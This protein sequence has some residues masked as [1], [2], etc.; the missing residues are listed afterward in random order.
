MVVFQ[1]MNSQKSCL[2]VAILL[3]VLM[4]SGCSARRF[5]INKLGDALSQGGSTFAQDD[6]PELVRDAV[7]FSL[8]L[9]ESLLAES[10][11]HQGLLLA[12]NRG[13]AQYAY[14]FVQEDAD[15]IEA[16][17]LKTATA[18][19]ERARKL[20][21][22]AYLYGLRGIEA[23]HKGFVSQLHQDPKKALAIL[24]PADL[25]LLYWSSISWAATISLSKDRPESIADLPLVE[26]MIDR[27]L[28]LDDA[29]DH[30]ALHSFL[31]SF[32]SARKSQKGDLDQRIKLHFERAQA[33][34]GGKQAGPLV[35]YA[36]AVSVKNQNA[37][38]FKDLL[39]RALAIN[40]DADPA[41]RLVNLVM[42]R[43]ARW[44]LAH[45]DDLI[46]PALEPQVNP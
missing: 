45:M 37:E 24:K 30:G 12:A 4:S 25:P 19:R 20:Y 1:I 21:T 43:R 44:L 32:E 26:S 18:L 17:D 9:I 40:P 8:K 22:R 41:N 34:S 15:E 23:R 10:P 13:F 6:D 46:L 16:R 27:A 39:N 5:A 28:E 29:Y 33:L 3:M 2:W 14:A 31:I 42:Q 35:A 7:P 36:E 11:N 38:E